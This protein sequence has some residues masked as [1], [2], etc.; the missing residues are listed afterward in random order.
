MP[1][2]IAGN[3]CRRYRQMNYYSHIPKPLLAVAA[4]FILVVIFVVAE[5]LTVKYRG[6]PVP[7]PDIPRGPQ[8]LGSGPALT[9]VVLGDSTAV[10]QGADY[11]EGIAITTARYLGQARQVKLVNL[12]ISGARV[13]GVSD[14]QVAE[15]T[16]LEPDLVLIAAGANDVT[17]LTSPGSVRASLQQIVS[18]LTAANCKVK[19]VLTGA[20]AMGTIPRF[21]QPIRYFAGVRTR[22]INQV[23]HDVAASQQLTMAP[24]AEQTH[25]EFATDRSLFAPDLFHPS[26]E[27]Y[28]TWLPVLTAALDDALANQPDHCK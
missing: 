1:P 21:P 11:T 23:F 8:T 17:H 20:P 10:G 13:Q 19:I 4:V 12:G 6:T 24:I 7:V 16:K 25:D 28:A 18:Q 2:G 9:Y 26:A 5:L 15:A 3:A 22:Q 14:S 27:G